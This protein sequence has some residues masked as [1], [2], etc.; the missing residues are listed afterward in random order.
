MDKY[1]EVEKLTQ[2]ITDEIFS[3]LKLPPDS[4]VRKT[5]GPILHLPAQRFA[6]AAAT[7]DGYVKD[8]GFHEAAQRI[9]PLFAQGFEAFNV[10]H[11][12]HEGPLLVTSN[13]PGTCDSLVIAASIP[14][15]DLKIVATGIPFV[16][17]IRNA[18]DHLIY[19]TL[20][21][22]ERMNV[23]RKAIRHLQD[24]GA[25]LIFPTGQ[26]DRDPALSADAGDD[27]GKWS[28]SIEFMLRHVPQTRVLLSIVSGVLSA[29]WR[30][31]PI[32]RLVGDDHM[33]RSVAEFLQVIQQMIIPNS[34]KITPRLTFSDPLTIADLEQF[35]QGMLNGMIEQARCLMEDHMSSA[36]R[37]LPVNT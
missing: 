11:I 19:T 35:S 5:L 27:L 37:L 1:S 10:A 26:I 31:N 25:V 33:Q 21:V 23:V 17:G 29:R 3:L 15:P 28:P 18:A 22:H 30:W 24:G 7:F 12:P 14:R 16:Q 6:Q 4:L 34:I 2:T 13:H 9:L 32:V 36:R 8:F 20:D